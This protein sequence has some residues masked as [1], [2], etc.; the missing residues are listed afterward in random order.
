MAIWF[1]ACEMDVVIVRPGRHQA[2][3]SDKASH[4]WLILVLKL[5][6]AWLGTLIVTGLCLAAIGRTGDFPVAATVASVLVGSLAAGGLERR[7]DR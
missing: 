7:R 6:F 3:I 4:P 5:F 1:Q 2:D